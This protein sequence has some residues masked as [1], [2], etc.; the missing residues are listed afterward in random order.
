MNKINMNNNFPSF[1][2][3]ILGLGDDGHTASIFPNQMKT[4]DTN[5]CCEVALHPISNQKRIT[6]TKNTINN[7]KNIVFHVTGK[8]KSSVVDKLINKLGK[9]KNYPAHYIKPNNGNLSWFL[10][11]SA[12]S[13]IN[14][15][16]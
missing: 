8:N 12:A 16:W 7:A 2:L 3:I 1:D 15:I 11:F 5:N 10:D 13:K 9:Y 14:K 6:L 4:L